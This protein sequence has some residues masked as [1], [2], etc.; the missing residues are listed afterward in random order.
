MNQDIR[1]FGYRFALSVVSLVGLVWASGAA[2]ALE[3]GQCASPQELSAELREEGGEDNPFSFV[4]T[5]ESIAFDSD[6][7]HSVGLAQFVAASHDLSRFY[8]L[9]GNVPLGQ[10]AERFC[11]TAVGNDLEINDYRQDRAPRL[12]NRYSFDDD[13]AKQQ[14]QAIIKN[15][16]NVNCENR[17]RFL[18]RMD[19]LYD[20]RVALQG[21][22]LSQ[23]GDPSGLFTIAAAQDAEKNYVFIITADEGATMVLSAGTGFSFQSGVIEQLEAGKR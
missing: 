9:T 2:Y 23:T 5:M 19:S 14:C 20:Q 3:R 16:G 11:I 15:T 6:A 17:D 4:A 21:I 12:S 8:I 7:G 22:L 18:E 10:P 13:R 1:R